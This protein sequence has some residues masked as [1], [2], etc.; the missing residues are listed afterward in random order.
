MTKKLKHDATELN[1]HDR[2]ILDKYTK[3]HSNFIES[4]TAKNNLLEDETFA[5]RS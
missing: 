2:R 3:F 5:G 4:N 1:E